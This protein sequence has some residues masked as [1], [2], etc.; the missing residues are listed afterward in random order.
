[1]V[2]QLLTVEQAARRLAVDPVAVWELVEAGRLPV[3]KLAAHERLLEADLVSLVFA[4][5]SVP[6][7]SPAT[8]RLPISRN[9]PGESERKE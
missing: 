8:G 4:N 5:R 7:D 1:M 2:G 6:T 9:T 3:V